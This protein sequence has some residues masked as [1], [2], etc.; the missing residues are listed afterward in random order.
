MRETV[1]SKMILRFEPREVPYEPVD[2]RICA[3]VDPGS[4]RPKQGANRN[5]SAAVSY[6]KKGE[7]AWKEGLPLLRIGNERI[8]ENAF[9]YVAPNM[10][11]G[12]IFDLEPGTDYERRFVPADPDGVEGKA[13]N[14]VTVRTRPE[15]KPAA[16]GKIYGVYPPGYNGPKQPVFWALKRQGL[17]LF[18][19]PAAT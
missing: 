3:A 8:N 11:A 7:Q 19:P 14:T 9:N 4:I 1:H 16:G 18:Y 13:E 2:V 10:F 17:S 6:R 12:S 5:A 15:P